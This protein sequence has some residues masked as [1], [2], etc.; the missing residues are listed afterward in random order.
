MRKLEFLRFG[1]QEKK[2]LSSMGGRGEGNNMCG[3]YRK[4]G[5]Q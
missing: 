4:L 5:I 1:E 2:T 3:I